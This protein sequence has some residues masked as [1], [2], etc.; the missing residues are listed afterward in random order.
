MG[1]YRTAQ[2]C[3]NGH[4]ITDSADVCPDLVSSF[5]SDCGAETTTNC[6]KCNEMIRGDYHVE[7]VLSVGHRTPVPKYCHN[8]GVPYPWTDSKLQAAR[9]LADELD[10]L[11]PEDRERLKGTFSDLSKEGPQTEVAAFRF[12][13]VIAKLGKGA[14]SVMRDLIVDIASE[15]AKKVIL[16]GLKS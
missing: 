4:M 8:C 12:K 14:A 11:S 1:V 9:D 3:W 15:T 10:E 16:E 7:G 13:K 5:C 2:I 6:S